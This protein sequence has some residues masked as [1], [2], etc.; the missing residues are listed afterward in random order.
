MKQ[1]H[2]KI[3][4]LLVL[5]MILTNCVPT[6]LVAKE[7]IAANPSVT[8]EIEEDP[9]SETPPAESETTSPSAL[10]NAVEVLAVEGGP[11]L[12]WKAVFISG[13]QP[14]TIILK[15]ATGAGWTA[16][17]L[18]ELKPEMFTLGDAFKDLSIQ[19]VTVVPKGDNDSDII[20]QIELTLSGTIHTDGM[21]NNQHTSDFYKTGTVTLAPTVLGST[22]PLKLEVEVTVPAIAIKDIKADG[23]DVE[24]VQASAKT[25][26]GT[27]YVDSPI[28]NAGWFFDAKADANEKAIDSI[29][30]LMWGGLSGATIALNKTS[31]TGDLKNEIPFTITLKEGVAHTGD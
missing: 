29:A 17:S 2:Q 24:L 21:V 7:Q 23:K 4:S 27:L 9:V 3:A 26:T 10:S 1:L 18:S 5:V 8:Q 31:V 13:T 12:K 28:E 14:A 11:T 6:M 25:I 16:A 15:E 20:Q 30:Y 19:S 22:D